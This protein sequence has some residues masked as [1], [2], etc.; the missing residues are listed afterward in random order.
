MITQIRAIL[1]ADAALMSIVN[2]I[3]P[4]PSSRLDN[5]IMYE[6]APISNDGTKEVSRVQLT[7]VCDTEAQWDAAYK[8]ICKLLITRDDRPLTNT[9][10]SVSVNGGGSLYDDGR[11]KYHK[12][13]YLNITARSE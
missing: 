12:I 1:L 2:A 3:E 4:K 6:V 7:T 8:R 5:I 13:V 9:I 11:K 10:L